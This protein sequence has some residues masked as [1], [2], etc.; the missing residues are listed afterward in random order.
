MLLCHY[1]AKSVEVRYEQRKFFARGVDFDHGGVEH[2]Q[3]G[4]GRAR[5][6]I[7]LHLRY[8][9]VRVLCR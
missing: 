3:Q 9:F 1:V 6:D 4:G 2:N 5:G 8:E 7:S